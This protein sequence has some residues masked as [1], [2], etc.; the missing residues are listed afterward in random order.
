[1]KFVAD[2]EIHSKYARAVS[3][4]M[5]VPTISA[6]AD[7]KG[8]DLVGTG[9]F[10]HP[11][12]LRE[13]ESHLTESGEGV[14]KFRNSIS[15]ARFLLT[16]E[17]SCMYTHLGKGRRVHILVFLPNFNDVAKFNAR[18]TSLGANLFSDGRPIVGLTL[19]Q[20]LESALSVSPKALVI[21]AHVWT[22]WFGFYGASSGYDSLKDAF[23]ESEKYIPA[24]E[25][26]L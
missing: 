18:L 8:I 22:P 26:G 20:I 14:Y 25:T 5:D 2:L 4:H 9:D 13:L 10:T 17:I 7:K 1:M 3:S 15:K 16:T 11:L 6:W 12:W 23:G 19:S 21:P 24:F